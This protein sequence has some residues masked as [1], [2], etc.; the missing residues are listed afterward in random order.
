MRVTA[1]DLPPAV[2]TS[3]AHSLH[4]HL[5]LTHLAPLCRDLRAHVYGTLLQDPDLARAH[6]RKLGMGFTEVRGLR[7]D[8]LK[9]SGGVGAYEA[10]L[11]EMETANAEAMVGYF[12]DKV[13][14]GSLLA[15]RSGSSAS[16][17]GADDDEEEWERELFGARRRR[18]SSERDDELYEGMAARL[19]GRYGTKEWSKE[20]AKNQWA[21]LRRKYRQAI[22]EI[23][24]VESIGGVDG[25]GISNSRMGRV[26]VKEREDKIERIKE[27]V[28]N[29]ERVHTLM[30]RCPAL[31]A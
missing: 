31:L 7:F 28:P 29:F 25:G 5:L 1:S 21:I 19:N 2:I 6:I 24:E 11:R 3:I 17:L 26:G 18:R 30:E 8:L 23:R 15:S 9:G 10:V 27:R 14:T 22:T 20:L 12:E 13:G 4:P 16:L